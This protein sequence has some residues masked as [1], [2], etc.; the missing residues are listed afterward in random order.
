M[1][2]VVVVAVDEV[3]GE[4]FVGLEGSRSVKTYLEAY[5]HMTERDLLTFLYG[6]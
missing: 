4:W 1:N 6:R 2:T 3:T 5:Q